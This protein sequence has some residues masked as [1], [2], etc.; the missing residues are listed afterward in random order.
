[1]TSKTSSRVTADIRKNRLYISLAAE[2]SKKELE[3][4]YT[5]IR[6]CVADLKPK[7]DIITDLSQCTLGHL[8]GLATYRKI[9]DYLTVKQPGE[10][11]R[12]VGKMSLLFKQLIMFAT[13]FQAYKPVYVATLE[14]AEERLANSTR[15]DGIRFHM[16]R[17]EVEYT[18]NLETD[19]GHLVDIS[20][21]GCAIQ[22]PTDTLAAQD[23]LSITIPLHKDQKN[24]SLFRFP[25]KIV[26]VEDNFFAAR[27]LQLDDAKKADLYQCLIYEARRDISEVSQTRGQRVPM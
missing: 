18:M 12:V 21:S 16:L 3:K 25:A 13:R 9:M 11:I 10:V 1:M 22:G 7:F 27:F 19:K 4:V 6:F 24:I 23:E 17:K 15:R 14:E 20:I 8:N 2:V 26:R 5:D